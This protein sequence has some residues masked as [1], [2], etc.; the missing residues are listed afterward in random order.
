[1]TWSMRLALA[2]IVCFVGLPRRACAPWF[3]PSLAAF[4]SKIVHEANAVCLS[5]AAR[6]V[7]WFSRLPRGENVISSVRR[8]LSASPYHISE[9]DDAPTQ[10][11]RWRV[12]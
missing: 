8:S 5:L 2:P 7:L 11:I 12:S 1:M 4:V 9:E 6:L 3:T 10:D